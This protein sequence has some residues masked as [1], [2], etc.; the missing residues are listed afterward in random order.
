MKHIGRVLVTGL[1]LLAS[2]ARAQVTFEYIFDGGYPLAV[3]DNG[4]VVAGN[5]LDFTSCR[6]TQATGLL[7]L[8]RHQEVGGA[9]RPDISADG[10]SIAYGIGSLDGSYTTQGRWTLGSGWQELMP[11][12]PPDGGTQDGTY[13]SV[14]GL[15]GDGN[16]VV[17]LYNRPGVGKRAHASKWTQAT[18]VVDLGGTTSGQASRANGVNHDG[19]VIGGWV[20]TPQGPWRPAVWANGSLQLLTN[21]DPLTNEGIGEVRTMSP[22]GEFLAGFARNALDSPRGVAKWTRVGGTYQAPQ[23]LGWVAG[24][25]PTGLNIPYAVSSDGQIIIGYCTFDGSPFSVTGFVW[26]QS[27]GVMDVNPGLAKNGILVDP[28]FT[29]QSLSA[30]TPDGAQIFGYGQLLVPPYTR[31]AFRIRTRNPTDVTPTRIVGIALSAP[32]PNPS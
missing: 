29:I 19:S 4:S 23:F 8:G 17:G 18:G 26:T 5:D 14:W 27:T 7:A 1:A 2:P 21:Y 6:W 10:T 24:T 11:P 20:E 25:E 12:A 31:R 9:G 28:N 15:S 30:M 13:G 32:Q 3:S 22:S 16:T